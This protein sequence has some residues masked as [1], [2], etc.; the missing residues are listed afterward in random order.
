MARVLKIS[1]VLSQWQF[2]RLG[3]YQ[4][5]YRRI[6]VEHQMAVIIAL[7]A[8]HGLAGVNLAFNRSG[9]GFGERER[10]CTPPAGQAG[11]GA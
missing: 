11:C 1:D 2:R 6:G 3:I 5:Y 7:T 4:D 10:L 9:P 8:S